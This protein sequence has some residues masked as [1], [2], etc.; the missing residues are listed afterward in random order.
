[1]AN[2]F[3]PPQRVSPG[4]YRNAQGQL[5]RGNAMPRPQTPNGWQAQPYQPAQAPFQ[6]LPM[7]PG[8]NFQMPQMPQQ[9][10]QYGMGGPGGMPMQNY[11]YAQDPGMQ[12]QAIQ[13]ARQRA[14]DYWQQQNMPQ[15][16]GGGYGAQMMGQMAPQMSDM[17]AQGMGGGASQPS[18]QPVAP[19]KMIPPG[20]G[21]GLSSQP[22]V[23][24]PVHT[25][26]RNAM[27]QG[28]MG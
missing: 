20:Q 24:H 12:Q 11:G 19:P 13:D 18:T 9:M 22:P 10:P 23:R 21:K 25:A 7:Q 15:G 2:Q 26:Q 5:Q 6:K 8:P 3:Q 14:Q 27:K 1:M 16:G 4:M 28:R 17:M